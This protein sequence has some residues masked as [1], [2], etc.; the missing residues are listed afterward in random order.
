MKK[1]LFV[2]TGNTCRSPMAMAAFNS[3]V[4]LEPSLSEYEAISAGITAFEGDTAAKEAIIAM[5]DLFGIDI[6]NHQ[7]RN[8]S[9]SEVNDAYI[10]LTMERRHKDHIMSKLPHAYKKIFTLKEY[11]CGPPASADIADPYASSLETYKACAEEISE[12][13]SAL[14]EKIKKV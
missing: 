7:A 6:S 5:K 1:I 12:A 11:A 3:L 10:V 9:R 4:K 13:V 2:C 8:L 14:I